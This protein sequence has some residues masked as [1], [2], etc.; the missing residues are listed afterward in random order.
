MAGVSTYNGTVT[1]R[2]TSSADDVPDGYSAAVYS[3]QTNTGTDGAWEGAASAALAG[4]DTTGLGRFDAGTN[5]GEVMVRVVATAAADGS[6]STITEALVLNSDAG[7]LMAVDPSVSGV[8]A[9]LDVTADTNVADTF[10]VAW[11][12]TTNDR[13]EFRVTV[14]LAPASLGGETT[15]WFV[16][17]GGTPA[18]LVSSTR[19]WEL[20]IAGGTAAAD[21]VAWNVALSGG[22]TDVI[23]TAA[24]LRAATMVRVESR[25]GATGDWMGVGASVTGGS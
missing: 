24:E 16:A 13:S 10:T 7:T 4:G 18:T 8:T 3:I 12:A 1:V 9:A 15:L 14:Q 5:D 25:Q 6:V 20:E 2:W 11:D 23:I 21:N 19:Q 22:Q 17:E